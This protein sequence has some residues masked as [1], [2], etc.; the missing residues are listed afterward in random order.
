MLVKLDYSKVVE[1][2][3]ANKSTLPL[4]NSAVRLMLTAPVTV[5][6]NERSFS[7]LKFVKNKLR[8]SMGDSRLAGLMFLTCEKDLTDTLNIE[9]VTRRWSMLIEKET[10][11]LTLNIS[12][13]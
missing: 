4:A 5:A 2:S 1:L 3:E 9:T 12:F 8:T 7:K 10:S 13:D 11:C 6:S